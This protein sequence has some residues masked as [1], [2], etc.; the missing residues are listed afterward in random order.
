MGFMEHNR[1]VLT[2]SL[3]GLGQ[4]FSITYAHY[5]YPLSRVLNHVVDA[6]EDEA[7]EVEWLESN[8]TLLRKDSTVITYLPRG[9]SPIQ[10]RLPFSLE[11]SAIGALVRETSDVLERIDKDLISASLLRDLIEWKGRI[12]TARSTGAIS[13]AKEMIKYIVGRNPTNGDPPSKEKARELLGK[14]LS[15]RWCYHHRSPNEKRQPNNEKLL[16]DELLAALMAEMGA[17][18]GVES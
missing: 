3:G 11:S 16:L 5:R 10:S 12:Q 9:G 18:R 2:P 6:L 17:R 1:G 7:K 15:Y 13:L 14:G 8:K 4:S